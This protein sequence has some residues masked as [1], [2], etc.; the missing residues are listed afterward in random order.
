MLAKQTAELFSVIT[1]RC[2]IK[3][4]NSI[5]IFITVTKTLFMVGDVNEFNNKKG[6]KDALIEEALEQFSKLE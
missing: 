6:I 1:A 5:F 4:N 2:Y 3:L